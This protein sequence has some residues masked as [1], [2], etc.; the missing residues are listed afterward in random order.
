LNEFFAE[1]EVPGFSQGGVT[2]E[3]I[4]LYK[5]MASSWVGLVIFN[6]PLVRR[7]GETGF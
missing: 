3:L 7:L 2:T 4:E 5:T 6:P 1:Y